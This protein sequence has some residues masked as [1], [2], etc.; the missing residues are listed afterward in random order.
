MLTENIGEKPLEM[1][2]NNTDLLKINYSDYFHND[3]DTKE[4]DGEGKW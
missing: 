3:N 4:N 2:N 1:E